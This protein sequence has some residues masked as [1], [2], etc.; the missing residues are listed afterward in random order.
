MKSRAI[1]SNAFIRDR[2]SGKH[3][4]DV[5]IYYTKQHV[6]VEIKR[7]KVRFLGNASQ[8]KK[9]SRKNIGRRYIIE[10]KISSSLTASK[11]KI[12]ERIRKDIEKRQKIEFDKEYIVFVDKGNKL[13][14]KDSL[15]ELTK[16][17]KK[18]RIFYIGCNKE[19][20]KGRLLY[21]RRGRC[22]SS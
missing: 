15:R 22:T 14:D 3:Y 1:H 17:H 4:A 11:S 18:A 20:K 16:K 21:F 5:L 13:E 9:P 10:I 19:K 8:S 2:Y 6:P 12:T 7:N